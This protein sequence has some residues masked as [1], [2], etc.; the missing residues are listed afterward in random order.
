MMKIDR[1][2]E[3]F[4]SRRFF[5]GWIIVLITFSTSMITAGIGGYGLSFFVIP[6]SE[7]L[8]ISRTEFAGIAV[9]RLALLPVVPLLGMMVDKKHGPRV[10]LVVGSLLAGIALML[11]AGV[12]SLWQFYL[13]HGVIF[14]MA[15]MTMGGQL[16]GP[17]VVSKWFIRMR[18]RAMAIGTMG[19]SAGG[20]MIAPLAGWLVG[21]FGWRAAWVVLGLVLILVVAPMAAIFMRR[22]PEDVGMRPDGDEAPGGAANPH[23]QRTEHSWT[24][25][26]AL[27]SRTLWLLLAVES[28]ASVS[29]LPVL[30]HQVAYVQDKGFTVGTAASVATV[31]AAFALIAKL[32]WG[33]LAERVQLRWVIP[34]CHIPAGLSLFVLIGAQSLPILYLY[35]A[36]HGL[37]MGGSPTLMNVV[38]ASYF[39]RRHMGAIRGVVTPVGRVFGA[40]GPVFAGWAWTADRSYGIPFLVF[41]ITWMLAGLV[42]LLISA[43][44]QQ[45]VTKD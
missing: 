41:G 34:L 12:N 18:G 27:R 30:F 3:R 29:L 33:F 13:I 23:I 5:Y 4:I 16:V 9:F 22:S 37:T 24:L 38:W 25:R 20:V 26:Q 44:R 14:G 42:M 31:L 19:I 45:P 39:G 35:A 32:P 36:L 21:A 15:T 1:F 17:S 2:S 10:M 28:L 43:P 8:G 6:M 40:F 7:T 11:T